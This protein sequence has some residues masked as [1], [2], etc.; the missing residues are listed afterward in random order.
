MHKNKVK[1]LCNIFFA[2]VF[3]V[4]VDALSMSSYPFPIVSLRVCIDKG[5]IKKYY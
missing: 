5:D 2:K 4:D 1:E 3:S